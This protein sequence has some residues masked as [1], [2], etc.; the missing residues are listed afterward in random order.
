ME[1][2]AV[3]ETLSGTGVTAGTTITAFGTGT[4]GAGTYS[5]STSQTVKSEA[6]TAVQMVTLNGKQIPQNTERGMQSAS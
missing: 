5:V 1:T 3:G 2:L 6:M 4:G